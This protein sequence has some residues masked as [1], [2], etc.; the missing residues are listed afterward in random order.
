MIVAIPCLVGVRVAQPEIGG[1][2]HDLQ[3]PRQGRDDLLR[4]LVR[5]GAEAQVDLREIDL[6]DGA[7]RRE[8]H[9]PQEGEHLGHLQPGLAVGGQG[10]D[11]DVRMAGDQPDKLGSGI[12][13]RTKDGDFM[14][15][16]GPSDRCTN[17]GAPMRMSVR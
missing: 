16:V 13:G 10:R 2:V 1:Q 9:V 17:A 4:G 3:I 7:E 14:G 6:V 11:F 5:Q 12:A 8:I 15:H